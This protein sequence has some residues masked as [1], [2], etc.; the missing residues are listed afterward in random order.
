LKYRTILSL[1]QNCASAKQSQPFTKRQPVDGRQDGEPGLT[2]R[3]ID[4]WLGHRQIIGW[5]LCQ[6][7]IVGFR[8]L[9]LC[10]QRPAQSHESRRLGLGLDG[11]RLVFDFRQSYRFRRL[12]C[13]DLRLGFILGLACLDGLTQLNSLRDCFE[14]LLGLESRPSFESH[15]SLTGFGLLERRAREK[16][17]LRRRGL[18]DPLV[19][20]AFLIEESF[21]LRFRESRNLGVRK[22]LDS[23]NDK[24]LRIE[25]GFRRHLRLRLRLRLGGDIDR[26]GAD[27]LSLS[28]SL[29]GLRLDLQHGRSGSERHSSG[30]RSDRGGLQ[31]HHGRRRFP[32]ASPGQPGKRSRLR[33]EL[34]AKPL[35]GA[36]PPQIFGDLRQPR[37]DVVGT[38][39]KQA[40]MWRD[41]RCGQRFLAQNRGF[42]PADGSEHLFDLAHAGPAGKL[43]QKPPAANGFDDGGMDRLVILLGHAFGGRSCGHLSLVRSPVLT[44][45]MGEF[46]HS[47]RR[48]QTSPSFCGLQLAK[49]CSQRSEA[50]VDFRPAPLSCG[51]TVPITQSAFVR[52]TVISILIGLLALLSIVVMTVWLADRT[53]VTSREVAL[54]TEQRNAL[55]DFR[56]S[57]LDAETGQRGYLLTGNEDYRLPYDNATRK[58]GPQI[59]H[60]RTVFAD[61]PAE[62][63]VIE[64]LIKTVDAKLS[65]L[66]K[67]VELTREKRTDDALKLVNTGLGRNQM[68]EARDTLARLISRTNQSTSSSMKMQDDAIFNLRLV[69][70]I[71]AFVILIVAVGTVVMILRY[72]KQ[73]IEAER[74]VQEA[75]LSLEE[76]VQERTTDLSRANAEIQRFAYI[77][78]H[79]LRAPLVN[80]MGF[81]SELE[82]SLATIQKGI[83]PAED[84]LPPQTD[85]EEMRLAAMEDLPESIGF[86]RSSTR[87]MDGLINA[88][89]KLSREGR[90]TLKPERIDLGTLLQTAADNVQHLIQD[91]DGT[92]S[93]ETKVQPIISDRLAIE[94][95]FG[96]LLDNAVKYR[97]P[98]RPLSIIIRAFPEPGRLIAVTIE[99]NGRGIAAQDHDRVFD[100]FRRSGSQDQPGE[101]IGL[102]H[103]RTMVRNLGGDITLASTLG[104]GTIFK[105]SLAKDLRKI[106]GIA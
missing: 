27:S 66:A 20:D 6:S 3:I 29:S 82:A 90:R 61:D 43:F 35:V 92:I 95:I 98:K 9:Q 7:Q 25:R 100:L 34:L 51:R 11:S 60:L 41:F 33:G 81:T 1:Q 87:K 42:K 56:N 52:S 77:V 97:N 68:V 26:F 104:Q 8:F 102:A 24:N 58:I 75:N 5:R 17:I 53:Q 101:G 19:R 105:V 103:V 94:Q 78:T 65:E 71:G 47:P 12:G 96:N 83:A 4:G 14:R 88:I 28:L 69:T 23:R 31:F 40:H 79:D 74:A 45:H 10:F 54:A 37:G 32:G 91:A 67:T 38:L 16:Q 63:A 86:I 76:R 30:E 48:K 89:L 64:E 73:L 57:L 85:P 13:D 80:I 84:G 59:E 39:R 18:F 15:F 50:S 36:A 44:N 46:S 72:M 93:I 55:T 62:K 22:R 49:T 21:R 2:C 106:I 99:D 70:F